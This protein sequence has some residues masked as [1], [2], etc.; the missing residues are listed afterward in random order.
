MSLKKYVDKFLKKKR[1][2]GGGGGD[3]Q[4]DFLQICSLVKCLKRKGG[5]H[6]Q[7]KILINAY[8]TKK[9]EM[10]EGVGAPT[11]GSAAVQMR[12]KMKIVSGDC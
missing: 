7:L 1:S 2:K 3:F 6:F 11:G 10:R 5:S 8:L 4:S 9:S 12:V